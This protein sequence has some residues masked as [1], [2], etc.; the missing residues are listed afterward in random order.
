MSALVSGLPRR[1]GWT[2]AEHAGDQWGDRRFGAAGAVAGELLG[3]R[4]TLTCDDEYPWELRHSK[5]KRL[6]VPKWP[7]LAAI[8]V[9]LGVLAFAVIYGEDAAR[10]V[11]I[12]V[13]ITLGVAGLAA[14]AVLQK[15][16]AA[17]AR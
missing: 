13:G 17:A 14:P 4:A 6:V 5:L 8:N 7:V 11:S 16:A 3:I 2:I 1:N 9:M 12:D 15:L 10:M